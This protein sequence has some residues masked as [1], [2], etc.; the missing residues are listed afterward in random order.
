MNAAAA[1][2]PIARAR[3][4]AVSQERLRD[5]TGYTESQGKCKPY[6][7]QTLQLTPASSTVVRIVL[8]S[9]MY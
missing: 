4:A 9:D 1:T 7:I 2:D 6:Y 3:G 5:Q 8:D